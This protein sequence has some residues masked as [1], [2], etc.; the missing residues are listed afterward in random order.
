M[1]DIADRGSS[2]GELITERLETRPL[3]DVRSKDVEERFY[4][5]RAKV[6]RHLEGFFVEY[7]VPWV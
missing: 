4:G 6:E 2:I 5:V 7:V 1:D 3:S